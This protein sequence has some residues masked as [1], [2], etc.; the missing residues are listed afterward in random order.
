M[1]KHSKN[2]I[3]PTMHL[4]AAEFGNKALIPLVEVAETYLSMGENTAK[5]RAGEGALPFPVVKFGNSQK[6]PYL[7]QLSVL[8]EFVEKQCSLAFNEWKNLQI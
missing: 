8:A 1:S 2:Q 3:T 5:R 4:L 6:S 7:V